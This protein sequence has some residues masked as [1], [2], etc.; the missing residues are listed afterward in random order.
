[1]NGF[2][3]A[4]GQLIGLALIPAALIWVLRGT[5][6][7]RVVCGTVAELVALPAKRRR[8]A[9][10]Q[11]IHERYAMW[12]TS[13]RWWTTERDSHAPEHPQHQIAADLVTYF[14]RTM[15]EPCHCHTCRQRCP[16]GRMTFE[17]TP[18]HPRST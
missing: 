14:Q 16:A 3:Y 11:A 8:L 6:P 5:R 1:M 15:P 9:E 18:R 10:A 17:H 4:L 13:L 2:A 12:C 7:G